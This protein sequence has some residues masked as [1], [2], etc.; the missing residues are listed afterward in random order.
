MRSRKQAARGRMFAASS[1]IRAESRGKPRPRVSRYA[2]VYDAHNA[3]AYEFCG[4]LIR[5]CAVR[6]RASRYI[7]PRE[8]NC[9]SLRVWIAITEYSWRIHATRTVASCHNLY[10]PRETHAV[11]STDTSVSAIKL[12][13]ARRDGDKFSPPRWNRSKSLAF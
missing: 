13:V 7:T 6:D 10:L 9:G 4:K 11:G 5:A 12:F 2:V 3:G 1:V 8:S